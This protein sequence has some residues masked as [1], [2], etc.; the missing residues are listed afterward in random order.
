M[1]DTFNP[2]GEI[3]EVYPKIDDI[4]K[5]FGSRLESDPLKDTSNNTATPIIFNKKSYGKF[6]ESEVKTRIK[7]CSLKSAPGLEKWK[8]KDV[9]NL[10][11]G[12][13]TLLFNFC[14]AFGVN[15]DEL[16]CRTIL[17]HKKGDKSNVDN[18]R[19]ITIGNILLRLYAKC[20]D[21]RDSITL[22]VRQ[23]VTP[24]DGCF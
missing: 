19:L 9:I 7:S 6:T 21:S 16:K 11:I 18:W 22:N 14:W 1:S 24:V 4:E 17:I 10:G 3:N 15:S 23:S 8:L 12:N 2:D 20:W 13:I 5:V